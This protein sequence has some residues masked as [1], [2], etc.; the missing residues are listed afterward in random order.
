RGRVRATP[1]NPVAIPLMATYVPAPRRELACHRHQ[2][3]GYQSAENWPAHRTRW[4]GYWPG[5]FP[6]TSS[7][8]PRYCNAPS[9][10]PSYSW[11]LLP[12]ETL[13]AHKIWTS[14]PPLRR[15]VHDGS[16][17]QGEVHH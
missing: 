2:T 11:T 9:S 16:V 13:D 5:W 4:R 8:G 3:Y 14:S 17:H 1:L 6:T 7:P 12:H 15:A 10:V